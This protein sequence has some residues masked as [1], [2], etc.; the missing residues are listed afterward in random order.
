M[1]V[2][3]GAGRIAAVVALDASGHEVQQELRSQ[4]SQLGSR[5]AM[6]C[7]GMNTQH[8]SKQSIS[9]DVLQAVRADFASATEAQMPGK[10]A[11]VLAKIV[12]GRVA[13]WCK[14]VCLLDQ[15]YVLDDSMT[16]SQLLEQQTQQLGLLKTLQVSA[17]LRV[18]VGEGLLR[19]EE[20]PGFAA[21]VAA[22]AAGGSI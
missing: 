9:Q 17:L 19:R 10:A 16:V 12:D 3:V 7:A 22:M 14:E 18:Q 8:I 21:E 15:K 2:A 13:K 11:E 4:L 5:L 6:H 20:N 1:P